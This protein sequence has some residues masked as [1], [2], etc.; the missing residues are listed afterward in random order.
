MA[1][2]NASFGG[3]NMGLSGPASSAAAPP[4][5]SNPWSP[6]VNI[7][8]LGN[9]SSA[10]AGASDPWASTTSGSAAFTGGSDIWGNATTMPS[11]N[12]GFS[13]GATKKNDAFDDI[14]SDFK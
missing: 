2:L 10:F 13:S 11:A 1:N 14:W 3:M 8:P 4:P 5:T 12:N 7:T 6:N 9:T